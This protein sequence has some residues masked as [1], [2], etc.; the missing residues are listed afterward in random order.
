MP[1]KHQCPSSLHLNKCLELIYLWYL[2]SAPHRSSGFPLCI[3]KTIRQEH[4]SVYGYN[5]QL[6]LAFKYLCCK[7]NHICGW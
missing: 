1:Y 3:L 4:N 5:Q 7:F 2:T 6:T